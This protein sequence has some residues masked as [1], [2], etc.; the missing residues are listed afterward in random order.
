ME[1]DTIRLQ[2]HLQKTVDEKQQAKA[3]Q[4][5]YYSSLRQIEEENLKLRA[6]V[7]LLF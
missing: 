5:V 2:E 6:H 7:S 4:S 3:L 1:S